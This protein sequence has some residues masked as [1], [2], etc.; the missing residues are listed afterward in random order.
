MKPPHLI[1]PGFIL[2]LAGFIIPRV[3]PP[4]AL[5]FR[6][7]FTLSYVVGLLLVV[8][9]AIRSGRAKKRESDV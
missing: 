7:I 2:M 3:V 4:P 5:S 8:L 9:G 6:N 1:L